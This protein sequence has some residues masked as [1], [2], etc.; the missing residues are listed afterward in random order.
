MLHIY[1]RIDCLRHNIIDDKLDG[2]L[3]SLVA[4]RSITVYIFSNVARDVF[5]V[6]ETTSLTSEYNYIVSST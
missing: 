2:M 5:L 4:S 3:L 6:Y 1:A